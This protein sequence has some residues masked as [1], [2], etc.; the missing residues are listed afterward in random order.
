MAVTRTKGGGVASQTSGQATK[1][2][3]NVTFV[4]RSRVRDYCMR[5][6]LFGI[7]YGFIVSGI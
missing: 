5:I 2:P 3:T 4:V 6:E 1:G 7:T